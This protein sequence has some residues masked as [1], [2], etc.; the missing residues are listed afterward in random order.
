MS[1][2]RSALSRSKTTAQ[3]PRLACDTVTWFAS[4]FVTGIGVGNSPPTAGLLGRPEGDSMA[5]EQDT[6]QRRRRRFLTP[7]EKYQV[8][9]EVIS[10][11]GTQRE[12]ADRGG[13]DR[14]TVASCSTPGGTR[15]PNLLIRRSP[16][17]VHVRPGASREPCSDGHSSPPASTRV[18]SGPQRMAPNLAPK[19]ATNTRRGSPEP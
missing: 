11:Q 14:S 12:V 13:V 3:G 19:S 9:C 16:S 17:R 7:A 10:G 2:G 15:T 18:R 8:W 6:G 4:E 1:D 5:E